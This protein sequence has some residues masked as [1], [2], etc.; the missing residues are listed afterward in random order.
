MI[1]NRGA[2][3]MLNAGLLRGDTQSAFLSWQSTGLQKFALSTSLL[4]KN[5]FQPSAINTYGEVLTVLS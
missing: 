1:E 4:V 3:P 5:D 2:G